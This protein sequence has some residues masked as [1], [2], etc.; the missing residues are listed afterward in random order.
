MDQCCAFGQN[1]V[2]MTF[3]GDYLETE[4][5]DMKVLPTLT[6]KITLILVFWYF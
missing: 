6:L 5:I 2:L 1:L 4:V 3:D